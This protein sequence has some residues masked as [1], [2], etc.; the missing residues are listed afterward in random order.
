M[1]NGPRAATRAKTHGR[2]QRGTPCHL[3]ATAGRR[4]KPLGDGRGWGGGI[5]S[6]ESGFRQT[7]T[8]RPRRGGGACGLVGAAYAAARASS[9]AWFG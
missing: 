4:L 7:R 9:T 5:S 6:A 3:L 8:P 1:D 2:K